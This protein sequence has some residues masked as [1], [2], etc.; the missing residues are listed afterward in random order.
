MPNCTKGT[1]TEPLKGKENAA[2][3]TPPSF[4]FVSMLN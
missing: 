4:S 3:L 1:K 2:G